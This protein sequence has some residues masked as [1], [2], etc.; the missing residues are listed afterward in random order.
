MK[1]KAIFTGRLYEKLRIKNIEWIMKH[2]FSGLFTI[3][4]MIRGRAIGI[5]NCYVSSGVSDTEDELDLLEN[6]CSQAAIALENSRLF[7]NLEKTYFD[8]IAALAAAIDAKDHYTHG[9]SEKVMEYSVAIAE[10]LHLDDKEVTAIKFA[11]LLHDVGK[12]GIDDNILKKPGM[13]TP[14]E[15][16]EIEK[17]PVYGS[18]IVEKVDFLKTIGSLT[19]HHH[20][21]WDGKGYP[22]KLKGEQIPM[23]ARILCVADTFDA[24]TS[25]R[26][27]R[28]AL[29]EEVAVEEIKRCSGSQF[30]PRIVKAF[31]N[32]IGRKLRIKKMK[33]LRT[34][35]LENL[36]KM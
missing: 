26:S 13:L 31:L 14:E 23:G 24:M 25:S 4:L 15:R 8:T 6:L 17:H 2:E 30:D 34:E 9:H 35:K 12:I 22:D 21:R 28:S 3:P 7:S 10:E 36:K 29:P 33:L 32:V 5:L 20:E 11:G 27:Y 16:A 19:F 18:K 1:N